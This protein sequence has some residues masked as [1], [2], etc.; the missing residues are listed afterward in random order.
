MPESVL[1]DSF[2][3][4]WAIFDVF[5]EEPFV[6]ERSDEDRVVELLDDTVVLFFTPPTELSFFRSSSPAFFESGLNSGI[7]RVSFIGTIRPAAVTRWCFGDVCSFR[8]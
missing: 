5:D 1:D 3:D 8:N 6:L 4:S 2:D 7:G